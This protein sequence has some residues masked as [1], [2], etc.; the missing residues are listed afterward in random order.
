MLAHYLN[1]K[2]STQWTSTGTADRG[3]GTGSSANFKFKKINGIATSNTM[4][5]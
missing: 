2:N 5:L 4:E 3:T 1:I